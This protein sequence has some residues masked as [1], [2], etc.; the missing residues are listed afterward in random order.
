MSRYGRG[1]KPVKSQFLHIMEK[2]K[3][4][5]WNNLESLLKYLKVLLSNL[6]KRPL[7]IFSDCCFLIE[8]RLY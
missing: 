3:D 7:L 8:T 4:V 1:I 6:S 2:I 5:Y